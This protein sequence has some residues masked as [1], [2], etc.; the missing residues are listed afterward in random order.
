[1]EL[2]MHRCGTVE[3]RRGRVASEAVALMGSLVVIEAHELGQTSRERRTAGEVAAPKLH[4]PVFLENGALQPLDEPVRPWMAR[5][6]ARVP[7]AE[8]PA[9][10]IRSEER[11]V[12]KECR[13]R[14]SPYH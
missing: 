14:W 3:Q 13:S 6:G 4:P 10:V 11:R 2:V 8:L 1:M 5:L 7:E 12:G 9:G